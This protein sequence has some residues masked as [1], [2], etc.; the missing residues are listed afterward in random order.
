MA[1]STVDQDGTLSWYTALFTL[2][3]A[4]LLTP[5]GGHVTHAADEALGGE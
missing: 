3:W 2:S 1:E 4:R 5:F